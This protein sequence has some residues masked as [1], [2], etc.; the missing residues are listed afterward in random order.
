MSC[1]MTFFAM[2]AGIAKPMPM[3]PP[4][5]VRICELMPISCP[6]VLTSAPPELPSLI[7]ASVW[8]KSSNAASPPRRRTPLGADDAHRHGLADAER[9]AHRQHDVADAHGVGVAERQRLQVGAIDLHD[10][11]IARLIRADHLGLEAAAVGQLDVHLLG[12]VD[13]VVVGQDVAVGPDDDAGAQAAFTPLGHLPAAP[14]LPEL[15]AEELTQSFGKFLADVANAPLRPN[16]HDGRRHLLDH[17][18]IRSGRERR[19]R[20]RDGGCHWRRGGRRAEAVRGAPSD[21]RAGQQQSDGG[22]GGLP[23]RPPASRARKVCVI[24]DEWSPIETR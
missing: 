3:L 7:G 10:R 4:D 15:V 19:R 8:M 1:V 22:A 24:H 21:H 5:D 17:S 18:G 12:A 11:Q 20:R 6:P 2:F 14:A 16:R 13:D 23:A 9:V